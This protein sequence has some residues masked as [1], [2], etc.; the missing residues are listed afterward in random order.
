MRPRGARRPPIIGTGTDNLAARQSD[1][2]ITKDRRTYTT[3]IL[4]DHDKSFRDH[5]AGTPEAGRQ[6][7][8]GDHEGSGSL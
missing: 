3:A 2:V 7:P 4:R 5:D 8:S 6:E 1:H